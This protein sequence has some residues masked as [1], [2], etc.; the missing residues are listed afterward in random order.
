MGLGGNQVGQDIVLAVD[1]VGRRE[2]T[3]RPAGRQVEAYSQV[4]GLV[5]GQQAVQ[6]GGR[7]VVSLDFK[8][9]LGQQVPQPQHPAGPGIGP[10]AADFGGV[11]AGDVCQPGRVLR[12][13]GQG[14][15]HPL[16]KDAV[17]PF[18]G[19][20]IL[21]VEGGVQGVTVFVDQGAEG[22]VAGPGIAHD[23]NIVGHLYGETEAAKRNI[24]RN[25]FHREGR[26]VEPELFQ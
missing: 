12:E 13:I 24:L 22:R 6:V 2:G 14:F 20:K 23:P 25:Q 1:W 4:T 3:G 10:V 21:P 17:F 18:Q 9:G 16:V 15:G 8:A 26:Q 11:Q 7:V 5:F 19:K